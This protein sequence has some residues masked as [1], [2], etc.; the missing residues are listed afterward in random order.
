M[1]RLIIAGAILSAAS[2]K[3]RPVLDRVRRAEE[4]VEDVRRDSRKL[5]DN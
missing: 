1:K 4:G 3:L 5:R 2:F